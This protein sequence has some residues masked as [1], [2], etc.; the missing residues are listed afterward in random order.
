MQKRQS[1][2]FGLPWAPDGAQSG[3]TVLKT[4]NLVWIANVVEPLR[5]RL[6]SDSLAVFAS[7]RA[8]EPVEMGAVAAVL[9][10]L[11]K[12]AEDNPG[13]E[14]SRANL[15]QYEA[16]FEAEFLRTTSIF[17]Q[18][19]MG[20]HAETMGCAELMRHVEMRLAEEERRAQRVLPPTTLP[21]LV[22]LLGQRLIV[23]HRRRL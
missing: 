21:K 7:A 13:E 3:A 6:L 9:S 22:E 10:S 5:A 15:V 23:P 1:E 8:G 16:V 14:S 20:T 11:V 19:E 17:Y 12:T 2:L 4:G 18:R